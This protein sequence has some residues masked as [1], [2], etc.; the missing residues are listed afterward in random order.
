MTAKIYA[1]HIQDNNTTINL[2]ARSRA[3]A[4]YRLSGLSHRFL[5]SDSWS[6]LV[7]PGNGDI[8]N[9]AFYPDAL[10]YAQEE[11]NRTGDSSSIFDFCISTGELKPIADISTEYP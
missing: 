11:A 9:F 6:Y 3:E 5:Y 2:F 1:Y 7:S 4:E 10:D 8:R